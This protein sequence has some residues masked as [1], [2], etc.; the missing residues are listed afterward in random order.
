VPVP[1]SSFH[2]IPIPVSPQHIESGG[3]QSRI[4]HSEIRRGPRRIGARPSEAR[5]L[6]IAEPVPA[7]LWLSIACRG[8]IDPSPAWWFIGSLHLRSWA[9]ERLIP[10]FYGVVSAQT[11]KVVEFFL[12][13]EAVEAMIGEVRR[14]A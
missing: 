5:A 9:R 12:E 4:H 14:R 6:S 7:S 8:A 2:V 11:E 13:H 1:V 3:G 10:R